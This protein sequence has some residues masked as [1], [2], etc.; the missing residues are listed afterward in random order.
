MPTGHQEG[1]AWP[2]GPKAAPAPGASC[3]SRILEV[4]GL[5]C[6][7]GARGGAGPLRAIV[8]EQVSE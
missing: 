3:S 8:N 2:C 7:K 6:P 4:L 5:V 1:E